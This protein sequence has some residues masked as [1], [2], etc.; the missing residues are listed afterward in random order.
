MNYWEAFL[1]A[2]RRRGDSE[3]DIAHKSKMMGKLGLR[4]ELV[5][6]QIPEGSEEW[7]IARFLERLT[8]YGKMKAT[9]PEEHERQLKINATTFINERKQN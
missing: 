3:A 4:Q 6:M 8:Y 2:A 7:Q 9:N 5:L 1:E